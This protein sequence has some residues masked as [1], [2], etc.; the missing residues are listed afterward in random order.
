MSIFQVD[1][2]SKTK[3]KETE[4]LLAVVHDLRT[5]CPWDKKQT[6]ES[7]IPYLLE[8]ANEAADAL[9]GGKSDE[10]CEELGDVLLQVALHAELASEKKRFTFEDVAKGLADKMVRRHPHIYAGVEFKDEEDHKQRW[11]ELKAKEKPPKRSV[12]EGTPKG[13][14]ALQLAQRYG[15]IA[16]SVGFDWEAARDVLEKVREETRELE[17][18]MKRRKR[19]RAKTEMELGDLLFSI[20]QLARHLDL[21][22]EIALKRSSAKFQK[23]F[24]DVERRLTKQGKKVTDCSMKELEALWVKAKGKA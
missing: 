18:E 17:K 23:R 21:N 1:S 7:L 3:M 8:E 12:L 22:A 20:C 2:L 24:S 19:Q 9:L 15:E 16:G 6:H 11:T 10:M 4:R 13:L 14:P 5:K